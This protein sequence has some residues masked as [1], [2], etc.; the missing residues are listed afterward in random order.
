MRINRNTQEHTELAVIRYI[1]INGSLIKESISTNFSPRKELYPYQL[2][3][4]SLQLKVC[5][6]NF[7]HVLYLLNY[8]HHI[9]FYI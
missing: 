7:Y 5:L 9:L 4:K 1:R 2:K 8:A 3:A 6:N